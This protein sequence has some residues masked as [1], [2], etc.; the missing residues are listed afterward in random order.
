MS[1]KRFLLGNDCG[2]DSGRCLADMVGDEEGDYVLYDDYAAEVDRL[3]G[4]RDELKEIGRAINDPRVHNTMTIAEWCEETQADLRR[5]KSGHCKDCC[6]ARTWE[7]LG[8]SVYT[9]R[10]IVEEIELLRADA[11][12][13]RTLQRMSSVDVLRGIEEN[14]VA[15]RYRGPEPYGLTERVDAARGES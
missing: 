6:C 9:G 4:C 1:I 12:R 2:G 5:L 10:S 7:A 8:I 15:L 14:K 3:R 11:E 13:W